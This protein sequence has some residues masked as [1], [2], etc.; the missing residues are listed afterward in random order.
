M[1]GSYDQATTRLRLVSRHD[2]DRI[3][4]LG[5]ATQ[6]EGVGSTWPKFSPIPVGSPFYLTY[7][8]K[9]DYGLL[10]RNSEL[11]SYLYPQLWMSVIDV[12]RLEGA[13]PGSVDPSAAP[14]W[15]PFQELNQ[16]NHLGYWAEKVACDPE[17]E[18]SCGLD[19]DAFCDPTLKQCIATVK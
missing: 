2:K 11:T 10:L 7:S 14:V 6:V 9:M 8:S 19:E 13:A 1:H 18:L 3:F 4:D 16:R 15:L 17:D 5:A 12:D